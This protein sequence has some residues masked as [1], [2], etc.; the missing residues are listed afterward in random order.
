[1]ES[2]KEKLPL[3][4]AV[5]IFAGVCAAAYYFIMVRTTDYFTQ[6]D[7][8]NVGKIS[9]LEY[10]YNLRAYDEHGKI[11]EVT[12]KANKE[13]REDAF[14]KLKMMALRGVVN[15]EEVSYD[16]LPYDVKSRYE[17]P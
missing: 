7:N 14:L 8:T 3:F 11:H 6:I 10:E 17:K 9:D 13:L 5:I 12:F 4:I 16:E 15:W 1:M 2:W